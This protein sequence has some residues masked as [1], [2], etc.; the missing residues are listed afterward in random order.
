[1]G[2]LY[3]FLLREGKKGIERHKV[4]SGSFQKFVDLQLKW[5]PLL[6]GTHKCWKI[7][8]A[9]KIYSQHNCKS[10]T[11]KCFGVGQFVCCLMGE[12]CSWS[13][14]LNVKIL[15]TCIFNWLGRFFK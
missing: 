9:S 5:D 15:G 8:Q 4:E 6:L 11:K 10:L 7:R 1:M 12:V 13:W 3:Y 14:Q 2:N